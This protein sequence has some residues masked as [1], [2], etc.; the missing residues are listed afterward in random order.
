MN[1]RMLHSWQDF[2][3]RTPETIKTEFAAGLAGNGKLFIG[4]LLHPVTVQPDAE[5]TRLMR[6]CF[7]FA[8]ERQHLTVGA[9]RRSDIAILSSPETIRSQGQTWTVNDTP[10]RGAYF[11]II[12][13]GLTADI[14]YDADLVS[15]L[16]GYQTLVIPELPFISRQAGMVIE[17]FVQEGGSLVIVGMLPKCVDPDEPDE[18]ADAGV[19]QRL[20]GLASEGM[21]PFDLGYLSL[22]GTSMEDLWREGDDFLPDIPVHGVPAKVSANDA[23]VLAPL[24]APGQTYQIGARPAGQVLDKPALASRSFGQSQVLF[25]ALPLASDVWQRGNPGAR[26]VI[27]GMIRKVSPRL[28]VERIGSSAVQVYRSERENKTLIHLVAYQPDGRTK[29]PHIIDSPCPVTGIQVIIR[30]ERQFGSIRLEPDDSIPNTQ[31]VDNGILIEIPPFMT[32]AAVV[33]N[34]QE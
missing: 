16:S 18:A 6:N 4:D 29:M 22:R 34:W 14:L 24:V 5:A 2:T 27:E 7:T 26:Y 32:H 31:P 28:R 1:Q 20:T 19:F 23:E 17:K 9:R 11:A 13:G 8:K 3:Y 12:A 15:Y 10:I 21:H 33:I 25:C 30:D